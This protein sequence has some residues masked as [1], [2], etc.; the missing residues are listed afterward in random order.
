MNTQHR[1][2]K[3]AARLCADI[4]AEDGIDP[5][6]LAA[7]QARKKTPRKHLQLCKEAARIVSL[8]LTGEAQQP[9]VRDLVVLSVE[10]DGDGQCIRVTVGQYAADTPVSE[11]EVLAALNRI[12]GL[13]R[14][15]LAQA[16]H[17]KYTPTLSFC[18]VGILDGRAG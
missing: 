17:R 16:L 12:Q 11:T 2:T 6:Y 18:Y 7:K 1:W 4:G 8:V 14:S 13:L 5:R 15:A 9:L 10:P 3:N